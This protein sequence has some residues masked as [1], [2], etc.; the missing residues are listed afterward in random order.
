MLAEEPSGRSGP[1]AAGTGRPAPCPESGIAMWV[2][3]PDAAMGLRSMSVELY[4]CGAKVRVLEG[5]PKVK[6]LDAHLK[7]IK[8]K[9]GHGSSSVAMVES[10]DRPP[11]KVTLKP[12]EVATAGIL[13]RN[14]VTGDPDGAVLAETLEVTPGPGHRAE[15]VPAVG[16]DL[17][18]T[19]KLGLSPWARARQVNGGRSSNAPHYGAKRVWK[20]RLELSPADRWTGELA[21]RRIRPAL[22]QLRAKG[23]FTAASVRT[24]L[25]GLGF[26][27]NT[28]TA[29]PL[30]TSPG[31]GF[32][33][34][35]GGASCVHGSLQADRRV[36][37]KVDGVREEGGCA[38]F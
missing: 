26:P 3:E 27:G 13:W 9:V 15:R 6:L 4:N 14:L 36:T 20:Q 30:K 31:I 28:T 38:N 1:A 19:R 2:R 18:T 21:A 24:T 22:E 23:G 34:Y 10:Y 37:A 8:V 35:P 16:I 17:G 29:Y 5:Y 7:S 12:G 25:L 32:E 11:G 33:V